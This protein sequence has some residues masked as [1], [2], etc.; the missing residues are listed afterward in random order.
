MKKKKLLKEYNACKIAY[1][2]TG[3]S[4]YLQEMRRI[5]NIFDYLK[6]K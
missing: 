2:K 1:I 4:V 5:E 6:K 3:S